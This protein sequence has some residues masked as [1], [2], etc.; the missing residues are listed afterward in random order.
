MREA[1]ISDL[2]TNPSCEANLFNESCDPVH[3]ISLNDLFII[4]MCIISISVFLFLKGF[5]KTG[6]IF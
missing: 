6:C 5:Y 2:S 4:L 3:K 1:A